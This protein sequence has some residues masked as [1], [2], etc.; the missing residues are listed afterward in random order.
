V[1]AR[2]G[3]ILAAAFG[4]SH[5]VSAQ[6][7]NGGHDAS[8]GYR[9]AF[10]SSG[11]AFTDEQSLVVFPFDGEAFSIHLPTALGRFAFTKDGKILYAEARAWRPN[12]RNSSSYPDVASSPSLYKVEFN[13]T[14]TSPVPASAGLGPLFSIAVSQRQDKIVVSG[15]Y[16]HTENVECGLFEISLLDGRVRKVLDNPECLL[17]GSSG[18]LAAWLT[19]SLSPDGQRAVATRKS[20]LE[21]IN[22]TRATVKDLG[23]GFVKAAWSPDG[24]WIAA[25]KDQG[26]DQWKTMLMDTSTFEVR[27]ALGNS[28]VEWSPDSRYLLAGKPDDQCENGLGTL[29]TVDIES[30]RRT[31]IASS[32]CKINEV[33]TAWVSRG[34][35]K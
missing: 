19:I 29:E 32:K 35:A 21:L 33:T 22:L 8:G 5:L 15:K 1:S 30:G 34:I 17:P 28:D 20:H 11:A 12:R 18:Y 23:D 2:R 13:P 25:L 31:T 27:R 7:P 10:Y 24:K 9:A 26:N 3:L 4:V 14:R 16:E 6:H